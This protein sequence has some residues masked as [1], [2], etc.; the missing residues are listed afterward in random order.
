MKEIAQGQSFQNLVLNNKIYIDKTKEIYNLLKYER[1][2]ISRPR[3]F[4]KSLMLDTIATLFE[5]G[6]ETSFK[7]TWIYNKWTEKKYPILRLNFLDF[8]RDDFEEYTR[9]LNNQIRDFAASINLINYQHSIYSS[10][11]FLS[12]FKE[13]ESAGK[14]IV[15]LIDEY[16]SQLTAN[17]N[18]PKLYK[19]FQKSIKRLYGIMKGKRS[20]KFLGITG[21]TRLKDIEIL[22]VGSDINDLS[23]DTTISTITGFTRAEIKK[24]YK[25]YIN[26]AVSLEKNIPRKQVTNKDRD[27]F[28]DK[29]AEEYDGYCFDEEYINKVYST[30]SVNTFFTKLANSKLVRYG[31]YWFD[32][33]GLP[34]VLANYLKTHT[35]KLEDYAYDIEVIIP[36][37]KDP[38]SLLDMKQEVLM[39][40]LGYLTIHDQISGSG[41][42]TLGFPNKEVQR[43]LERLIAYKIFNIKSFNKNVNEKIFSTSTPDKIIEEL[44]KLMNSISYEEYKNI[45]ERTIQGFLHAFMIGAGQNV[46]TEKHSALG[47]SDLVL[48]YDNRRLVFELKYAKTENECVTKLQ[49]AIKQIQDRK[50]G[51]VLPNKEILK[52]AL[53]FNGDKSVRQF[54]CFDVV[55]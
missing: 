11:C 5:E 51:E 36:D 50:Y 15:I 55:K 40:Q 52:L 43:A 2:F 46:I 8:G 20:I 21:V 30:W 14:T 6:V 9:L 7:N 18:N 27:L 12:L 38:V 44:N 10:D 35:I 19:K 17:I 28:L 29:L 1:V 49:E 48:E 26:L 4:G 42:V 34:S 16:D 39:C 25:D 32:N 41:S 53:V 31:D 23:Y 37:F 13:L 3:R 45:N 54:T 24:Y 22:S 47:R 33:G